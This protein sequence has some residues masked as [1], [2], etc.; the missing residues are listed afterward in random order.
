MLPATESLSS[1]TALVPAPP[2]A[3][4]C[5][6][7]GNCRRIAREEAREIFQSGNV[8]VA[9]AAFVAGRL[10]A[11]AQKPLFDV[12]ELFA[13]VRPGQPLVPSALGLARLTGLNLPQTPEEAARALR[14]VAL[15]LL[16]ESATLDR[17][18][19]TPLLDTLMRA[20]WRWG[21]LL[22]PRDG[23]AAGLTHCRAG[24]LARTADVGRR[25][26]G[27]SRPARSPS[28]PKKPMRVL[29]RLVGSPR[30]G[31][32]GLQRSGELRLRPARGFRR[33]PR[34]AG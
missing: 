10:K 4:I 17:E 30:P 18:K 15:K 8:L 34:S 33:T 22:G 28:R 27:G 11:P 6:A 20:G 26:T 25:G 24:S 21:P 23:K 32:G 29:M 13:F 7:R 16:E 31:A 2:G 1:L 9:H 3:A 12:L 19:I 14:E 5:D